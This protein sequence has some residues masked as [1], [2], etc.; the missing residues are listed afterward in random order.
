[1]VPECGYPGGWRPRRPRSPEGS[2][3]DGM[4]WGKRVALGNPDADHSHVDTLV[5]LDVPFAPEAA[6]SGPRVLQTDEVLLLGFNAVDPSTTPQRH[7]GR[8]LLGF[9]RALA[10][11]FGYPNDEALQGHPLWRGGL[12]HYGC[13]EVLDSTWKATLEHQNMIAFPA[14]GGW[15]WARHFIFTFHDSTFECL[16]D[17]FSVRSAGGDDTDQFIDAVRRF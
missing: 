11:R 10:S 1:V 4:A 17:G 3:A 14:W 5:A 12:R 13:F 8:V 7:I 2:T 9:T 16:A 15:P 6:V